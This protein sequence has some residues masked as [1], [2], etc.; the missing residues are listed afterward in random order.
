MV[1]VGAIFPSSDKKA[2]VNPM[3]S[4][5]YRSL[6]ISDVH[7]G[8]KEC[9]AEFLVEFL[10]QSE[11]QQIYLVGDLVDFWSLQRGERWLPAHGEVLKALLAKAR[12]GVRVL[13]IPGNH[14]E[15]VRDIWVYTSAASKLSRKPCTLRLTAGA[16]WCCM[17]MNA[18]MQYVAADPCC[19][20]WAI[21]PTICCCLPIAGTTAGDGIGIIPIGRWPVFSSSASA[22]RR[23]TLPTLRWRR[24]IKPPGAAWMG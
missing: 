24:R 10:R 20:G 14:D 18:T 15:V 1:V 11:C 2:T 4:A 13:Y 5:P 17:A 7:L 22:M 6:W 19:T 3:P 12:A 16:F 9:K 23:P 21:R 8:F